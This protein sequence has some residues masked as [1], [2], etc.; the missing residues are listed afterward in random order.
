[1]ESSLTSLFLFFQLMVEIYSGVFH[2]LRGQWKRTSLKVCY[3]YIL[4]PKTRDLWG[5]R[6]FRMTVLI[7]LTALVNRCH[8]IVNLCSLMAC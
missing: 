6:V 2:R 4:Q 7:F 1:M 3:G 8:V 5:L